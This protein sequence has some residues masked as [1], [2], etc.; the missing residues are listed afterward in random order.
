M[1][2]YIFL[3]TYQVSFLYSFDEKGAATG[4]IGLETLKQREVS[5]GSR[6]RRGSGGL[7][8]PRCAAPSGKEVANEKKG[9]EFVREFVMPSCN[10]IVD[11]YR[12]SFPDSIS[13]CNRSFRLRSVPN[14]LDTAT[15]LLRKQPQVN[16]SRSFNLN[17]QEPRCRSM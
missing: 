4:S 6:S 14:Y 17:P 16:P 3:S 1:F 15:S 10:S 7:R 13:R 2:V 8:R 5:R 11:F 9:T 12:S